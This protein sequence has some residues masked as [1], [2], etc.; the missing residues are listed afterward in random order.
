MKS[1][2]KISGIII[3]LLLST[4]IYSQ[5]YHVRVAFIGNS[6]TI[7]TGLSNAAAQCYPSQ[8]D[9][10]LRNKY[11]DTCILK[12]FA[13][14]GRTMLKKGDFPIWNE[15][16]FK[17]CWNFAPNICFIKLGTNDSKPQN[18]G[19]HGDE[20]ISDFKAMIDTFKKRNPRTRFILCYP[21]PAF[22]AAF[23]INDSI[24]HYGV[25]PAV[26]SMVKYSNAE[27]VDFRTPL[28]NSS[29]YFVT[30]GIHP[31]AAG[32]KAMA[33]I[34]YDKIVSSDIIHKVEK[35][36]TY[37]TSLKSDVIGDLQLGSAAT[38]S[39]TTIDATEVFL[40]GVKVDANGSLKVTPSATTKYT[41]L[42]KGAKNNDSL[43]FEQV[44][45]KPLLTNVYTSI[46]S[47]SYKQNDTVTISMLYFDQKNKKMSDTTF[48]ATW[49]A[50]Q[51]YGRFIN[52]ENN[53]VDFIA[54]SAGKVVV[55][56]SINGITGTAKFTV[57]E[58]ETAISTARSGKVVEVFPNPLNEAA[59]IKIKSV[60]ASNV[61]VKVFDMSGRLCINET[62]S[63]HGAG[64]QVLELNMRSLIKGTYSVE[65][66]YAGKIYTEKVIKR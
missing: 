37:V 10:L 58:G 49:T 18:W 16:D 59:F 53:K 7:G 20:F 15:P 31:D 42:A 50:T 57:K 62:R 45:Y 21:C 41:L 48:T 63:L 5:D 35:G 38:F 32:A 8:I 11:G 12:N 13:V 30:D 6:I 26:D 3:I 51:G 23:D 4:K 9:T 44:V 56:C 22:S 55:N 33:K 39:W 61:F 29:S 14:S 52:N 25:M 27:L 43:I 36:Y 19:L 28:L 46:K 65:I 66:G 54:D 2:I 34:A 24:I 1:L 60:A 17:S 64:E 40:N 47:S